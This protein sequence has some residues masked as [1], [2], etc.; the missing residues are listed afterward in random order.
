MMP[1]CRCRALASPLLL[2]LLAACASCPEPPPGGTSRPTVSIPFI[3]KPPAGE[4]L[5]RTLMADGVQIYECRA[6]KPAD[7]AARPQWA[8]VAPE[9]TLA[10]NK[11]SPVGKHYAGPTWEASDGSKIVG[12]V[13]GRIDSPTPDN[14]PWLLL[15]TRSIGSAGLFANVTSVQRVATVGGVAPTEGCN[16]SNIGATARVAYKA[17][18][19]MYAKEG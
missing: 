16:P 17:Q 7:T 12:L 14:I 3:L 6:A 8:L 18:Y 15:A 10:D 9:A 4:V 19:A 5:Q 13:V 11:G 1:A 2:A